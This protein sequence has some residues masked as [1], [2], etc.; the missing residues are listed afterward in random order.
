MSEQTSITRSVRRMMV[1][2][3]LAD[4]CRSKLRLHS[5]LDYP[6]FILSDVFSRFYP[7]G[8]SALSFLP[9]GCNSCRIW[10][11]IGCIAGRVIRGLGCR[12][13]WRREGVCGWIGSAMPIARVLRLLRALHC[14]FPSW[15]NFLAWYAFSEKRAR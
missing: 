1:F 12:F 6:V 9:R 5:V 4:F 8:L 13:V 11:C 3:Y 7:R 2:A 15:F 10:C 14:S